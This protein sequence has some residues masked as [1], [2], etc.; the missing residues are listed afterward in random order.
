MVLFSLVCFHLN[1]YIYI[2]IHIYI[3][4]NIYIYTYIYIV[5]LVDF[6]R[7]SSLLDTFSSWGL[8][9]L[10]GVHLGFAGA[11]RIQGMSFFGARFFF[12]FSRLKNLGGALSRPVGISVLLSSWGP[13]LWRPLKS[14]E[15]KRGC[16][17]DQLAFPLSCFLKGALSSA[18]KN[19]QKL[20]G[21]NPF[22]SRRRF[23]SLV[24]IALKEWKGGIDH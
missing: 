23:G 13:F 19:R 4:M 2:Y 3:Y 6:K 17:L 20:L 10:E 11:Q 1:T 21:G 16:H 22:Q 7:S 18:P 15:Q 24:F 5:S 12:S 14:V 9:Q 8:N